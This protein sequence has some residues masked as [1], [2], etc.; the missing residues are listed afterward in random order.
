MAAA[1]KLSG[2]EAAKQ[3]FTKVV[4]HISMLKLKM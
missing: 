1:F 3:T 2:T 4:I